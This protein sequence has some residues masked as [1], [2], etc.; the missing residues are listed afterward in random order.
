MSNRALLEQFRLWRQAGETFALGTVVRTEGS[1][2][3][4]AGRQILIRANGEH[5]GLVSGGCLEGD[6]AEHA[7]TVI[8]A[9]EATL[10]DYDMRD[11]ADDL[12]GIGLGCNGLMQILLQ[13]LSAANDWQPF[14]AIAAAMEQPEAALCALV[15]TQG[16]TDARLGSCFIAD[17]S[18]NWDGNWNGNAGAPAWLEKPHDLSSIAAIAKTHDARSVLYWRIMPWARLLLLGAG[19]DALPVAALA[20]AMGWEITVADHRTRYL[21]SGNFSIADHIIAVEPATLQQQLRLADYDAVVVMSHHI[22]TDRHYLEQLAGAKNQYVGLL[23]PVA[24]KNKL[25][26]D[27]QLQDS[28]FATR[29]HGPVGLDIGSDSPETI[30]LAIVSEIQAELH[31]GQKTKGRQATPQTLVSRAI[32]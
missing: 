11:E 17:R 30:A 13:P 4:K 26:T 31:Q 22:D 2:Y 19:P 10:V 3:S 14:A 1:T 6:L 21:E 25:L 8:A 29:L 12:W 7:R 28:K 32:K 27:L 9:G 20:A 23:G 24:R 16:N 18:G 5:A 15:T